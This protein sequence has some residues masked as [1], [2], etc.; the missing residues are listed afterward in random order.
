VSSAH[1]ISVPGSA[2]SQGIR[3]TEP[4]PNDYAMRVKTIEKGLEVV[5]TD[6]EKRLF[7]EKQRSVTWRE[8]RLACREKLSSFDKPEP[9]DKRLKGS[10]ALTGDNTA[11]TD[12]DDRGP[13][14][15]EEHPSVEGQRPD[16]Q[17]QVTAAMAVE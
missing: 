8:H 1:P 5:S 7:K 12:P 14:L 9:E 4:S 11:A 3:F 10:E 13:A 17:D 15:Q 6:Q 16:Q 2:C